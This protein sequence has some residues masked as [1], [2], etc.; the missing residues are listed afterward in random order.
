[1]MNQT[2]ASTDNTLPNQQLAPQAETAGNNSQAPK[3]PGKDAVLS[4]PSPSNV[5]T[6]H[7]QE[8]F[9][10]AITQ[11][12]GISACGIEAG[13]RSGGGRD[14]ALVVNQG[15]V[16]SAG[17]VFTSNR[18][19]AAPVRYSQQVLAE[20]EAKT[21]IR[22]V[23]LNAAYANAAT[24][25]S[26][27]KTAQASAQTLADL[28]EI[29]PEQILLCSTGVIGVPLPEQALLEALPQ[30]KA[31][32]GKTAPD[33]IQA[34]QAILTTDTHPKVA[35]VKRANFQL[36]GMVK[37]AGMLAP[38][39]ATMLAVIVTDAQLTNQQAQTALEQ[40]VQATFNRLD[41]D[42]CM[43]TNDTV[44]LLGTG[45][46][47]PSD[48]QHF[49]D[50]LL[51]VCKDLCW[52]L[53]QDAEGASHVV[54]IEVSQARDPQAALVAARAISRSNLVKTAIAGN[55]PNWGRILSEL[56]TVPAKD[57]PFDPNKVNILINGVQ[58][59]ENG[60]FV[61]ATPEV[62]LRP[63]EVKIQVQLGYGQSE[64]TILTN[65]L[66]HQYVSINADYTS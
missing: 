53:A 31:A 37:G 5:K 34:A 24:G 10:H 52:Q 12:P 30:A 29:Q 20:A 48:P 16:P 59:A 65:D 35:S 55:D 41:S 23:L 66:T 51:Q 64:A 28:L 11:V 63:R 58:V 6:Q 25:Q 50:S 27:E 62:N 47:G 14:L 32:L 7:Y 40:A 43:S 57:C 61:L 38:G 13:L 2:P 49:A 46:A 39:L 44:I 26:G 17:A 9:P 4:P 3:A 54:Q 8:L 33:G 15:P 56:G 45:Q 36:A 1:M 60:G 22:A 21:P 19:A 18:F 42:G